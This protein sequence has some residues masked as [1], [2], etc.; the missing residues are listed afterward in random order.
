MPSK[1]KKELTPQQKKVQTVLN[2]ILNVVCVLIIL[3]ALVLSVVS[4]SQ[5]TNS[6]NLPHLGKNYFLA[7]KTDSMS[8]TFEVGDMIVCKQYDGSTTL[9][10][11]QVIT[12]RVIMGQ[13]SYVNTHRIIEVIDGANGTHSYRTQGDHEASADTRLVGQS[14][15]IA[16]WGTPGVKGADGKYNKD[17]YGKILKGVGKI[18][19]WLND[20]EH[21][22]ASGKSIRYFLVI[23]L[24]LIL[25]FVAYAAVLIYSLVKNK[26]AK[27]QEVAVNDLSEEEK[28][29]LAQEYLASQGITIPE[30]QEAPVEESVEEPVEE[31]NNEPTDAETPAEEATEEVQEEV[32]AE[33][34]DKKDEE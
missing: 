25:L 32:V 1:A 9:Q 22:T 4:I 23:V 3:F 18:N 30:Q 24:P 31:A 15:I 20:E 8:G 10:V 13:A 12:F 21:M 6:D 2:W 5:S 28:A 33:D 19:N 26:V 29:R 7:V 16:T 17:S 11:G 14:N 34:E 27:A